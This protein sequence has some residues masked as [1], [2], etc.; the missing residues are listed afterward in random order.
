MAVV[1]DEQ[2][3]S[4]LDVAW[5]GVDRLG[6]LGVFTTGGQGP[7]PKVYL[8]D[9]GMLDRLFDAIDALPI[10]SEHRLFSDVPRPDDFIGFARRGLFSFDWADVH[11]THGL[12]H[13]YEI[14]ARPVS[15]VIVSTAGLNSSVVD[16]LGGVTSS[17]LD[18]DAPTVDVVAA[19]E[20]AA[21]PAVAADGASR[22]R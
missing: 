16:S 17:L 3:P 9:E 4:H 10:V 20:C 14:Q 12:V 21:Q 5:V 18:F 13:A 7:I 2:Y 15:P 11:R 6:R 19:L 8:R 22:R 1:E